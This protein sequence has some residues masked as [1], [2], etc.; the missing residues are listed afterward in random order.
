VSQEVQERNLVVLGCHCLGVVVKELGLRKAGRTGDRLA[1]RHGAGFQ[2]R[3]A[4][5]K[6]LRLLGTELNT[7]EKNTF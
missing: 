6:V 3:S 1:W 7:I 5:L 2:W 4:A